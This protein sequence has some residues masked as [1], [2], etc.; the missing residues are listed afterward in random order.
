MHEAALNGGI[1]ADCL[2]FIHAVRIVRRKLP[3]FA[4]TPPSQEESIP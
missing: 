4:A 2:S 3:R 1:D